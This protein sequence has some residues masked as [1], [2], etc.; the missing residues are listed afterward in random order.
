[1][2]NQRSIYLVKLLDAARQLSIPDG[3]DLLAE[4]SSSSC[5]SSVGLV[6]WPARPSLMRGQPVD[7]LAVTREIAR[8]R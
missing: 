4:P 6:G 8:S 3:L 2:P 1:M 7:L 5:S